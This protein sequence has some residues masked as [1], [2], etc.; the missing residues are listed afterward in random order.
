M[1]RLGKLALKSS[2]TA[3]A[4]GLFV[5]AIGS[6][7]W[8]VSVPVS[9]DPGNVQY[10]PVLAPSFSFFTPSYVSGPLPAA[11]HTHIISTNFPYNYD[12]QKDGSFQGFVTSSIWANDAGQLAFTYVFNN[13]NPG[14]GSPL[15]D[16][17]RATI[18]DP[19]NPWANNIDP[20]THQP[21]PFK[22]LSV[23]SDSSGHSTPIN[24]FFG[25]WSNGDPF[26][27]QR[28]GTDA[29]ISIN[30]NPL[31]SGTQ[32]NSTPSDQSALVWVTTDATRAGITNVGLSDNGHVGTANA[33]APQF[34]G[35]IPTP[36]PSTLV[37]LAL[38]G[39]GCSVVAYR[40]KRSA[41]KRV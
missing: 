5:S 17:V 12:G 31:N 14:N 41:S 33:Y 10:N 1:S 21:T 25:S 20:T 36:E 11:Y 26:S 28:D 40:R 29:G 23:G 7:A 19:T 3:L 32:L 9:L 18:N 16:I 15:T 22:I 30:W 2:R 37:L 4:V 39:L 27:V 35:P 6:T 34:N 13:L 38:G 8:A 24:G